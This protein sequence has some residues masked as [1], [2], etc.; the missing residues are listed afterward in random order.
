MPGCGKPDSRTESALGSGQLRWNS[1]PV[2]LRADSQ[3]LL[4]G[5]AAQEDLLSA[6]A[7]W[8]NKAGR[9]LFDLSSWP[10]GQAPYRG[11]ASDPSEILDNVVYFQNPWSWESRIA[12]QTVILSRGSRI[13]S[14]VIFLNAET[15]LCSGACIHEEDHTSRRRLL[16]HELGHFLGFAHVENNTRNIMHPQIQRGGTL[17]NLEVDQSLLLQLTSPL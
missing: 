13:Q 9:R 11:A 7:F 3:Y 16:A 8:E 12:G 14:A 10:T 6:I 5:G 4:D 15:S 17:D 1:F 2:T